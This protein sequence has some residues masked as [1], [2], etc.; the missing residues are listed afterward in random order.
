VILAARALLSARL[1]NINVHHVV[2][3]MVLACAIHA[4][5]VAAQIAPV[6]VQARAV[7]ATIVRHRAPSVSTFA[8]ELEHAGQV[9]L[10]VGATGVGLGALL[11]VVALASGSPCDQSCGTLGDLL[12]VGFLGAGAVAMLVGAVL[13][14]VGAASAPSRV[15]LAA[16][17]GQLGAGVRVEL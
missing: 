2:A 11:A 15:A 13:W 7:P 16:G 6:L 17:P 4:S 12:V 1:M 5:P 10:G 14:A 3:A 8:L 9:T